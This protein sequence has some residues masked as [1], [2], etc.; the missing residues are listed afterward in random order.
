MLDGEPFPPDLRLPG[1]PS[2]LTGERN[3]RDA[4]SVWYP[5]GIAAAFLA[6]GAVK[7]ITGMGLPTVAVSLLALWMSP[8][9]AAALLVAPSLL[10]NAAQCQ[11]PHWRRLS[12]LLWPT[13]TG[14]ALLTVFSPSWDA[15]VD[16]RLIL[17]IVLLLYG[18]WGLWRP[19]LPDLRN[20]AQWTGLLAGGATGL[21]TAATAV[22]V[23]PLVPYLQ[24]LRLQK[25]EMVQA[26][27]LTFAIATIALATRIGSS[28][29]VPLAGPQTVLAVV[30][31]FAGMWLGTRVRTSIG[32]LTF[33]KALFAVFVVLGL[34]NVLRS[35]V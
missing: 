8:A 4:V 19:A 2:T 20:R 14:L 7:G 3:G 5:L 29:A 28:G 21:L 6:A 27:G 30:A 9:H 33:Q 23:M 17:G 10:T 31:A 24:S 11:G 13:W 25:D 34:A 12:A 32:P 16:V 1:G 35:I 22:F 15:D 18:A 26:L